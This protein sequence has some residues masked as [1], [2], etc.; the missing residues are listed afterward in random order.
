MQIES[1]VHKFVPCCAAP[2]GINYGTLQI[3]IFIG[4]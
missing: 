2:S 1:I 3:Y 4:T